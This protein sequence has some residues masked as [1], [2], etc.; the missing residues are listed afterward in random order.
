MTAEEKQK[1]MLDMFKMKKVLNLISIK[2]QERFPNILSAFRFFDNDH[3]LSLTLNEF[4]QGIEFLR[5]K[6]SFDYIKDIFSFL[7]VHK[8]GHITYKEFSMLNDDNLH[9]MDF[10]EEFL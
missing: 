2:I 3:Q 4:A 7:D 9:K 10:M 8:D 6:V 5:I 1:T